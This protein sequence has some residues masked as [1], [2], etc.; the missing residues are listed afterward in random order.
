MRIVKPDKL[1]KASSGILYKP[2]NRYVVSDFEHLYLDDHTP[3]TEWEWSSFNPWERRYGGQNLTGKRVLVYRH[4]AYGDQLMV[5]AIPHYLKTMCPDARVDL[6]CDPVVMDLWAGCPYVEGSA[7]PI[8]IPFDA[9][10]HEYDYHIMYEGM[11]EANGEW[12][13]YNAYDDMFGVLGLDPPNKFKRPFVTVRPEDSKGIN[14]AGLDLNMKYMV[15]HLAP[16]NMNRCYPILHGMKFLREF[17]SV[18]P[19]WN[20]IVVGIMPKGN[21]YNQYIVNKPLARCIDLVNR[22]EKFRTLVPIIERA[23]LVVCPDSSVLHLAAAFPDV[24]IVSLWGLFGPEDR[25]KYYTNNHSVW[26]PSTCPHAPCHNHDFNLPLTKCEDAG[27]YHEDQQYCRV[28]ESI[29]LEEILAA[30]MEAVGAP[31]TK[32][33]SHREPLHWHVRKKFSLVHPSRGRPEQAL[34]CIRRWVMDAS[35]HNDIEY[36]LSLDL[37]DA[38]NYIGMVSDI[39]E[40]D[41]RVVI[42]PNRSVV[43]ALNWGA[44]EATGDVLIYLSDDFECPVGWD[45]D[46]EEAVGEEKFLGSNP[47]K[48]VEWA[49]KVH[50]GNQDQTCTISILSRAYYEALGRIYYPEYFSVY[51]DNDFTEEAEARGVLIDGTHLVFKHNHYLFGGLPYDATYEKE[52]NPEAYKCGEALLERRRKEKFGLGAGDES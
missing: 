45:L 25:A 17:L 1:V 11:M 20:A 19:D 5:S 41:V 34:K 37:D 21:F 26:K 22:T 40:L 23:S 46:I 30:T 38:K 9:V 29:E 48:G 6:Y 36:I 3:N 10:Q 35:R 14:E 39:R 4:S 49:L 44:K 13:Q 33:K 12:D 2:F 32:L 8:P 50:D 27:G 18:Y 28:L 7:I 42:G 52:N 24:P 15:Y 16:A 51:V 47:L 43:D 31:R